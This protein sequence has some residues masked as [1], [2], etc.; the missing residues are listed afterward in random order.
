MKSQV[1]FGT[2]T[3]GTQT[4]HSQTPIS[5]H[6]EKAVIALSNPGGEKYHR[7]IPPGGGKYGKKSRSITRKPVYRK[8][9]N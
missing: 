1:R 3:A 9:E 6:R 4:G 5:E 8:A 2:T 7:E